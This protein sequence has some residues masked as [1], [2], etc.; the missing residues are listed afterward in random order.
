MSRSLK[1]SPQYIKQVKLALRRNR[2]ARQIDLAE[3]LQL[4]RSTIGNFLNGKPV[5]YLNFYE[6]CQKLGQDLEKIADFSSE[7]SETS[8]PVLDMEPEEAS[9]PVQLKPMEAFKLQSLGLVQLYGN[10][11][12]PRCNLYA[13][14]FCD[15]L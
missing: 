6:I 3:D 9:S 4:S 2:F 8:S 15:R 10:E 5:D 13:R 7:D 12:K 14:Y 1:V 11:V